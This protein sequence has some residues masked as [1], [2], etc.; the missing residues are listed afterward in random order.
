ME[1]SLLINRGGE[2]GQKWGKK[3]FRD[4]TEFTPGGPGLYVLYTVGKVQNL[5]LG[6]RGFLRGLVFTL[7]QGGVLQFF[8]FWS[9]G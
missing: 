3:A 6:N 8:H 1:C 5:R 9:G 4:V 2:F 7:E